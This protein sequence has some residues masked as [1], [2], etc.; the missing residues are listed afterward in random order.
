MTNDYDEDMVVRK[1]ILQNITTD[2]SIYYKK[3]VSKIFIESMIHFDRNK[4]SEKTISALK[5]Y[6]QRSTPN[7]DGIRTVLFSYDATIKTTLN[8]KD[9]LNN[10][11]LLVEKNDFIFLFD[12]MFKTRHVFDKNFNYLYSFHYYDEMGDEIINLKTKKVSL[13][14]Q[15]TNFEL[16]SNTTFTLNH[17]TIEFEN[18]KSRNSLKSIQTKKDGSISVKYNSSPYSEIIFDEKLNIKH[19]I[20]SNQFYSKVKNSLQN[21]SKIVMVNNFEKFSEYFMDAADIY[22][23]FNDKKIHF[24][25]TKEFEE[26]IKDITNILKIKNKLN[27][28]AEEMIKKSSQ[29]KKH[30]LSI[31]Q[32]T[33]KLPFEK[34]QHINIKSIDLNSTQLLYAQTLLEGFKNNTLEIIDNNL[35]LETIAIDDFFHDFS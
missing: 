11:V 31:K 27:H 15:L 20:M 1:E 18:K 2:F 7:T 26:Q 4:N 12:L 28:I 30:A 17:E 35:I 14:R 9:L 22:Q 21:N 34:Y 13:G 29:Y 19:F 6:L 25:T 16:N 10:Y 3:N 33:F 23:L 24:V 32:K 8:F 5:N